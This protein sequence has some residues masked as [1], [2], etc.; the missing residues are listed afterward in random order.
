MAQR[1]VNKVIL[2]GTFGRDPDIRYMPDGGAVCN[3]SI[4]TSETWKD[5]NSGEQ[6]E[7]TEWHKCVAFRKPAEI[8]GEYMK[9]GS[10]IFIEGKLQTRKWEKDGQDHYTTEIVV[11]QFQFVGDRSNGGGSGSG[12][13]DKPLPAGAPPPAQ[14]DAFDEEIPF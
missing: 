1:G 8:I 10:K 11:D 9:K 7:K 12:G 5:K 14:D 2:M 13:G 3:F 6:Q 4:A